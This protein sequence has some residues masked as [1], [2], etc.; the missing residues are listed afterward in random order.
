MPYGYYFAGKQVYDTVAHTNTDC[1]GNF[2]QNTPEQFAPLRSEVPLN[3]SNSSENMT[4]NI[5]E[6]LS[7]YWWPGYEN[8]TIEDEQL[9]IYSQEYVH[10]L[11]NEVD[12]G[13][14][15]YN[16][17]LES[18]SSLQQALAVFQTIE[19]EQD[20][21][22]SFDGIDDYV[23]AN[24]L[25]FH[26]AGKENFTIEFWMRAGS[27]PDIR[28]S[29]FSI[30]KPSPGDNEFLMVLIQPFDELERASSQLTKTGYYNN[31]PKDYYDAT[32]NKRKQYRRLR[33]ERHEEKS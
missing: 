15:Q 28:T 29:L 30:N 2:D 17:T 7:Q 25:A 22:L 12:D 16:E 3:E 5:M 11:W 1:W 26:L 6:G 19:E 24:D 23:D 33:H 8:A 14:I 9:C 10:G 20:Y 32:V 18:L 31:W 21:S 13:L 27:Q 4:T